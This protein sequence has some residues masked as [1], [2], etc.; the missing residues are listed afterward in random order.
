MRDTVNASWGTF[1]WLPPCVDTPTV[2]LGRLHSRCSLLVKVT[3]KK[4]ACT[5]CFLLTSFLIVSCGSQLGEEM[6]W[7]SKIKQKKGRKVVNQTPWLWVMNVCCGCTSLPV[8]PK[9]RGGGWEKQRR[10]RRF[11]WINMFFKG[12]SEKLGQWWHH[13]CPWAQRATNTGHTQ[14]QKC[15][16][17]QTHIY[18]RRDSPTLG[19]PRFQSAF[20]WCCAKSPYIIVR[21]YIKRLYLH[22]CS[23]IGTKHSRENIQVTWLVSLLHIHKPR[24]TNT[25]M[26]VE[27][28]RQ[29]QSHRR[30][31]N[32]SDTADVIR[33][34]IIW[35]YNSP[36]N[37]IDK[38]IW[39]A[40]EC[41]EIPGQNQVC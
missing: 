22:K 40:S 23:H 10:K 20:K 30:G 7:N 29:L 21:I 26:H 5:S 19:E 32:Q 2:S 37:L 41:L 39:L 1:W 35:Y 3:H 11:V 36:M 24:L 31:R 38:I 4:A 25:N 13:W 34:T 12:G 9:R 16:C 14:I 8:H 15:K 17:E 6:I 18:T 27:H 33:G 28:S